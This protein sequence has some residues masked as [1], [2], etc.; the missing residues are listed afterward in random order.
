[1][2]LAKPGHI[3]AQLFPSLSDR[4]VTIV[5]KYVCAICCLVPLFPDSAAAAEG[6]VLTSSLLVVL[7][8]TLG[9]LATVYWCRH[10]LRQVADEKDKVNVRMRLAEQVVDQTPLPILR[11]NANLT[12]IEANRCAL[13]NYEHSSLIGISLLDLHPDLGGHPVVVALQSSKDG[14][15]PVR[16]SLTPEPEESA[17]TG[18]G[19]LVMITVEGQVQA[20]WFGTAPGNRQQLE[21]ARVAARQAEEA[22]NRMK[23]EFVAN[24][25]HEVRTPMN[26]IIG[27]TE[28]LANAKLDP[29]EKRFVA[30]IHKS[31][32]ALVSIF[33][34]IMELSKIDSGR[35][36]IMASSVRLPLIIS[37][38]EGLF[39]DQA[40]EK[41]LH[42]H[43]RM[44]K[45]LPQSF[46]LDGVRL[47]QILQNL[48]SNAVKFTNEG[49]VELSVDGAPSTEKE[50]CFDLRFT[51]ND[52]GIG[53]PLADQ[54]KI[55]ELFRQQEESITREYGGVGLG[56]TL[57]SRLTTMMGGKIELSS[58]EGEGACFTVFLSNIQLA[59]Q[60]SAELES[61]R[62]RKEFRA[63]RKTV[64]RR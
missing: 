9:L 50:G 29:K 46:I 40:E 58:H 38:V 30:I 60:T 28:M 25:N 22:A 2:T 16:S 35:L 41:G 15:L 43:C 37:E 14:K 23:S 19:A 53:I 51:V 33:N 10:R 55:F 24:I 34:D 4:V 57:C 31:S 7:L 54:P 1:M 3:I 39:K 64:G 13:H 62:D 48:V 45:H 21:V 63:E 26:A 47:K 56:L 18:N 49:R 8:L 42:L 44:A 6:I 32:M 52:T 12:I 11:L 20:L 61:N 27:Y 36:Q 5:K 59:Q 17:A